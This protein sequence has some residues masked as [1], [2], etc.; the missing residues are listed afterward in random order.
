MNKS[1][2]RALAT[3]CLATLALAAACC[4]CYGA[5][6]VPPLTMENAMRM[7]ESCAPS[8]ASARRALEVARLQLQAAE[9]E[10]RPSVVLRVA[11]LRAEAELP[12]TSSVGGE[13]RIPL[14]SGILSLSASMSLL[15]SEPGPQGKGDWGA[16]L[17]MPI[18]GPEKKTADPVRSAESQALKA[19]SRLEEAIRQART[20]AQA[21]YFNVLAAQ[22]RV[23]AADQAL[24]RAREHAGFVE[25]RYTLG[26]A[27]DLDLL[28]ARASMA[29][30][31]AATESDRNGLAIA[32]MNLNRAI[33]VELAATVHIAPVGEYMAW[34]AEMDL[35][36]CV[37]AALGA[38]PEILMAQQDVG[39]AEVALACAI[40]AKCPGV[41]LQGRLSSGGKWNAGLEVSA[42][43]TPDYG[44]DIAIK[45]A[46]DLLEQA[47]ANVDETVNSIIFEVA[48]AFYSLRD[49][50]TAV[51]LAQSTVGIAVATLKVKEEQCR[52]GAVSYAEVSEAI[53]TV[54]KA[55]SDLASSVAACF[56]AKPKLRAAIGS[57]ESL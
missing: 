20:S 35:D 47:R 38:R 12:A 46:E 49:A 54:R 42:L 28:G 2:L 24:A 50:E 39:D 18:L 27:G 10:G 53:E 19:Q 8:V 4:A 23:A 25:S 13:V 21:A 14:G 7:A 3:A 34:P 26:N 5:P 6:E 30:A 32:R 29:K 33:G 56:I 37:Q 1:P 48:E 51:E 11:P 17:F 45:S 31:Q 55:K 22:D 43:L 57:G 36:A 16:S 9:A 40:A 15:L 44:A 41:S 52:M